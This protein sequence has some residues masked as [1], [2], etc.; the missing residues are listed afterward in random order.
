MYEPA[1]T[2][3]FFQ[4]LRRIKMT[5]GENNSMLLSALFCAG[6]QLCDVNFRTV[7]RH[8]LCVGPVLLLAWP[9]LPLQSEQSLFLLIMS[10]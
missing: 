2:K 1:V 9:V 10:E 5:G 6:I 7:S 4:P 3:D 8:L